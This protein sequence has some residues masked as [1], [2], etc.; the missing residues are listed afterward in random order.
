MIFCT[1]A[2]ALKLLKVK[3]KDTG[4]HNIYCLEEELRKKSFIHLT[5]PQTFAEFQASCQA[6]WINE[7]F[8]PPRV[9][10][11]SSHTGK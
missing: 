3:R 1:H 2:E 11:V 7:E 9:P 4:R 5:I 8:C 10:S 6:W